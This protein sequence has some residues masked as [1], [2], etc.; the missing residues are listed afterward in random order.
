MMNFMRRILSYAGVVV[1][2]TGSLIVSAGPG[3]AAAS[4]ELSS[5]SEVDGYHGVIIFYPSFV[6]YQQTGSVSMATF[7]SNGGNQWTTPTPGTWY[8]GN[9][10]AVPM[11]GAGTYCGQVNIYVSSGL[12]PESISSRP[13][14]TI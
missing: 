12:G 8:S 6:C 14:V 4:C 9:G 2:A 1:L 7:P 13:C 10:F 5:W 3:H 11:N